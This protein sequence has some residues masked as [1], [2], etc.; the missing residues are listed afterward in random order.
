[1]LPVLEIYELFR[2]CFWRKLLR[3]VYILS[4]F[5]EFIQI[6]F[7]TL[8][9]FDPQELGEAA[10]SQICYSWRSPL[11]GVITINKSRRLYF[12]AMEPFIGSDN[13]KHWLY[14]HNSEH[15]LSIWLYALNKKANWTLLLYHVVHMTRCMIHKDQ[16]LIG[17]LNFT[18][19]AFIYVQNSLASK[20]LSSQAICRSD[21][22][23][24]PL[25]WTNWF[26]C[27]IRDQVRDCLLADFAKCH[28]PMV[29]IFSNFSYLDETRIP[30]RDSPTQSK[31]S[32]PM[33]PA[34]F[35]SYPPILKN[36]HLYFYSYFYFYFYEF[37]SSTSVFS[38]SSPP[39]SHKIQRSNSQS[40]TRHLPQ[41]PCGNISTLGFNSGSSLLTTSKEK[42]TL[43]ANYKNSK[44][45][46]FPRALVTKNAKLFFFQTGFF[47]RLLVWDFALQLLLLRYASSFPYKQ[48]SELSVAVF[49]LAPLVP[50]PWIKL[51][52]ISVCCFARIGLLVRLD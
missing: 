10:D 30:P 32:N 44:R 45:H 26:I 29:Q 37:T 8:Y 25:N 23:F 24:R 43:A 2:R 7:F 21:C 41:I 50:C 1:M 13:T 17:H 38:S 49:M 47:V 6:V 11:D 22:I 46:N 5:G 33:N 18:Q 35:P 12:A 9:Y 40:S 20:L 15:V 14:G 36:F 3:F 51:L 42:R 4:Y 27:L 31:S 39:S 16:I 19:T 52:L 28:H 48:K 34:P